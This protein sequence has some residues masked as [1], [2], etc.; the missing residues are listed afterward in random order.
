MSRYNIYLIDEINQGYL[1]HQT[2]GLLACSLCIVM[3]D[4]IQEIQD[5]FS[6]KVCF[7][8]FLVFGWLLFLSFFFGKRRGGNG[9]TA[10]LTVGNPGP[11]YGRASPDPILLLSAETYFVS[12]TTVQLP[13]CNVFC[14]CTQDT[15]KLRPSTPRSAVNN[16]NITCN[17]Q[18]LIFFM[19][20]IHSYSGLFSLSVYNN[21]C[22]HNIIMIYS[23]YTITSTILIWSWRNAGYSSA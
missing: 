10:T 7:N 23:I 4:S 18:T 9:F 22:F 5:C 3:Y 16:Q 2:V 17:T 20:L 11:H 8:N 6:L 15:V 14:L 12:Q 19:S 13:P 21:Y 1:L